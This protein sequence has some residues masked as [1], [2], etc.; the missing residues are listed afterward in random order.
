MDIKECYVKLGGD[1]T[2]VTSR[3]MNEAFVTRFVKKFAVSDE[4]DSLIKSIKDGNKPEIYR[5]VHTIKGMALNLSFTKLFEVT[6][7]FCEAYKKM[8]FSNFDADLVEVVKEY[9]RSI[10][11]I[12][13]LD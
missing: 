11:I 6:N 5:S 8:D 12:K 3:L 4:Y 1:Y 7:K 2:D 9:E 10:E 13:K